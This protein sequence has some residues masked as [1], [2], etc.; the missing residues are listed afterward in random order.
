MILMVYKINILNLHIL[1]VI[2]GLLAKAVTF[3]NIYFSGFQ[4]KDLRALLPIEIINN[5]INNNNLY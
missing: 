2:K 3:K 4:I 5:K 1:L